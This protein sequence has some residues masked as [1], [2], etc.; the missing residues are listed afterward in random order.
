MADHIHSLVL[1]EIRKAAAAVDVKLEKTR[2]LQR[3]TPNMIESNVRQ[4]AKELMAQS[5][6]WSQVLLWAATNGPESEALTQSACSYC[7]DP[8]PTEQLADHAWKKHGERT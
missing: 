3:R 7:A 4:V 8:V 1:A 5:A 2:A 6:S